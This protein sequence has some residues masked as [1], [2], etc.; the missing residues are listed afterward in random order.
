MR[1]Y[2]KIMEIFQWPKI[3]ISFGGGLRFFWS[4]KKKKKEKKKQNVYVRVRKARKSARFVPRGRGRGFRNDD[5][6]PAAVATISEF[7][8]SGFDGTRRP[9]RARSALSSYA[10]RYDQRRQH[11]HSPGEIYSGESRG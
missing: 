8:N 1:E 11:H 9:R 7:R 4:K 5:Y 10:T 3:S 2:E 6:V